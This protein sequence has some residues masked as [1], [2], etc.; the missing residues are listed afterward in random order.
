MCVCVHIV[1]EQRR[2]KLSSGKRIK[3]M[4][5]PAN[6]PDLN[7]LENWFGDNEV[8]FFRAVMRL[9][10]EPRGSKLFFRKAYKINDFANE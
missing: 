9:I 7:P 1:T 10:K 5:W 4:T 8:I 2:L 6:R 3:S